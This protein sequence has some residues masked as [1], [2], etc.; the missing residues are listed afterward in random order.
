[1]LGRSEPPRL[2]HR[3]LSPVGRPAVPKLLRASKLHSGLRLRLALSARSSVSR[4]DGARLLFQSCVAGQLRPLFGRLTFER[5]PIDGEQ[6][7]SLGDGLALPKCNSLDLP[8]DAR[9]DSTVSV[10]STVPTAEMSTGTSSVMAWTARTGTSSPCRHWS[11]PRP[12]NRMSMRETFPP[13]GESARSLTSSSRRTS[14]PIIL[15][16]RREKYQYAGN[17]ANHA[18]SG[19]VLEDKGNPQD[20]VA[21]RPEFLVVHL[22]HV[23]VFGY[24]NMS[25]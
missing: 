7:L 20:L 2:L 16:G 22:L 21:V 10:G 17:D 9:L 8:G 5:I 24:S 12:G 15:K 18:G 1:M 11:S 3:A 23:P 13:K 6:Q 25:R 14:S 19:V 4:C